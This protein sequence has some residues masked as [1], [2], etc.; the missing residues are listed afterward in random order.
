MST[1]DP[2]KAHNDDVVRRT[3]EKTNENY[4]RREKER[5]DGLAER[6]EMVTSYVRHISVGGKEDKTIDKY[7][8]KDRMT[9]LMGEERLGQMRKLATR[10]YGEKAVNEWLKQ[11]YT[12]T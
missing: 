5:L 12:L 7:L 6:S 1:Y 2:L 11:K 8:G 9:K 10:K 3:I 4:R